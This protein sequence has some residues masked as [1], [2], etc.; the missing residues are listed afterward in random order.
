MQHAFLQIDRREG[1]QDTS[2]TRDGQREPTANAVLN[3]D[4]A[5]PRQSLHEQRMIAIQDGEEDVLPRGVVQILEVGHGHLAQAVRAWCER[6]DFPQPKTDD[7]ATVAVSF[8]SAPV[9]QPLC[10]PPSRAQRNAAAATEIRQ[11]EPGMAGIERRQQPQRSIYHG[12]AMRRTLA[13]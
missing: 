2:D 1:Q 10:Q 13:A 9:D 5:A 11:R 12:I 6:R 8:E 3:G 7:I 4:R